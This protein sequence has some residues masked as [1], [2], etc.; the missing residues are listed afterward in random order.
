MSKINDNSFNIAED[1]LRKHIAKLKRSRR[2]VDYG[3]S[4]DFADNLALIRE[5]IVKLSETNPQLAFELMIEFIKTSKQS[6]ERCDDS[7]GDVSGEYIQACTDLSIIALSAKIMIDEAVSV[8][9]SLIEYDEFCVCDDIISDF[10]DVLQEKGLSILKDKVIGFLDP[11]RIEKR[12]LEK[13][14]KKQDFYD[15]D[16]SRESLIDIRKYERDSALYKIRHCLEKIADSKCNVD[17]Y[18]LALVYPKTDYTMNDFYALDKLRVAERL[19]KSGRGQEALNWLESDKK[20]LDWD[21]DSVMD[22][23]AKALDL[24]GDSQKAHAT[25]VEWFHTT[26]RYDVFEQILQSLSKAEADEFTKE[27]VEY[28]F[29]FKY[30][31]Y[32]LNLLFGCNFLDKC[33]D[34]V[35]YRIDDITCENYRLLR[36][37]AKTLYKNKYFLSSALLYRKLAED[38][39]AKAISKYYKYAAK[40]L[41][42]CEELDE[43]ILD[44]GKFESHAIFYAKFAERH[45]LKRA[46]WSEYSSV[47]QSKIDKTKKQNTK[48]R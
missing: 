45:K 7:N 29:S 6:L 36:K 17:E 13:F 42:A 35:Q 43:Y 15:F 14:K 27:S 48:L 41:C 19:I 8:V 12:S 34:L 33:S 37:V 18:I 24:L 32:A 20:L 10:K 5:G 4:G 26:L 28:A 21:F 40:D 23:K 46:F 44:Y 39:T 25:R 47:I 38:L 11:E 9:F 22:L 31:D 2:F 30:F 16:D 3:E 1:M